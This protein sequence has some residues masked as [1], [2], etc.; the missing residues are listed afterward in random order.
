[1][2][3]T[4]PYSNPTGAPRLRQRQ[5]RQRSSIALFV[6]DPVQGTSTLLTFLRRKA[7]SFFSLGVGILVGLFLASLIGGSQ[8]RRR[9][10]ASPPP[11]F[12]G[13]PQLGALLAQHSR[14]S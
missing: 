14:T 5:R 6:E 11:P 1:M 3:Y 13:T 9:S 10:L 8:V 2:Q 12:P 7:G 4:S